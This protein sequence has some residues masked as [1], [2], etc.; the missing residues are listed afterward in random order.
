MKF[1]YLV[2]NGN[3]LSKFGSSGN[4]KGEFSRPYQIS[5]S[6]DLLYIAD[7]GNKRIQ[8]VDSEGRFVKEF[9]VPISNESDL[10][11]SLDVSENRIHVI[12]NKNTNLL[13]YDLNGNLIIKKILGQ[14]TGNSSIGVENGLIIVSNSNK[15][16]IAIFDLDGAIMNEFGS[17]GE[18]Y[19][20]FKNP[21]G[22]TVN[23]GKIYVSDPY[24]F[25]I[26]VFNMK[27]M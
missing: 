17:Q 27:L 10:E 7:S 13:I 24:N 12:N 9:S 16:T 21:R 11:I 20:E 8:V 4:Q 18:H 2:L 3:F 22:I 26:Q 25:R 14:D 23:D 6:N 5:A 1:K 19:G 15:N